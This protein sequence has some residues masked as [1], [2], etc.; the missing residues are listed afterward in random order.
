MRDIAK[1]LGLH[2]CNVFNAMERPKVFSDYGVMLWTFFF[3]RKRIDGCTNEDKYVAITW[4]A[5]KICVNPNK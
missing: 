5:S 3:Q 1:V 2:H 4:W